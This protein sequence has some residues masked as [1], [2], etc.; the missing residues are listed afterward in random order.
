[1]KNS[2][3]LFR[4]ITAAAL[5]VMAIIGTGA[6]DVHAVV[7]YEPTIR[8]GDN[9]PMTR[10][11]FLAWS[12]NRGVRHIKIEGRIYPRCIFFRGNNTASLNLLP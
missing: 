11:E 12:S 7:E 5:L 9:A 6:A 3:N 2:S 1:M 8:I 4:G 10:D